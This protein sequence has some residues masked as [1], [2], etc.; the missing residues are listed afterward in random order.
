MVV[1]VRLF[2][3]PAGRSPVLDFVLSLPERDQAL[4]FADLEALK[5]DGPRAPL[6]TRAIKGRANRGLVEIKTH[7]FRTFYC[8]K[9]GVVWV[10]HACRK[11]EQK[12]GIE[13]ARARMDAL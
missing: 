11:G 8:V 6:A 5:M 10:L 9:R 12:R 13:A 4:I 3:T 7:G 1:E 2:T